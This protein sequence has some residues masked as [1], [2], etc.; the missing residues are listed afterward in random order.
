VPETRTTL[1]VAGAPLGHHDLDLVRSITVE[2]S[3]GGQDKVSVTVALTTDNASGWTGPLDP[4]VAPAS[5]F[6]V[7]LARGADRRDVDARSVSTSW[8]IAPGGLSTITV[9]GLDR[10]VELDRRDVQRLWQDTNDAAIAD[11]LFHEHGLASQVDSTP[12]GADSDTYSPQQSG[13]DWAFLK[14][15]A[16]RNGFDVH[17]QSVNGVVT[18]VF[19]KVDVNADAQATLALG[20]GA[21][22]GQA[23]A[24]V[25]LMA[26]QEVHVTRTV[27][28]TADTDVA[29]DDG[30]GHAMGTRSLGGATLVRTHTAGSVSVLDA[31]TTATAMAE[32]SAFG[33]TLSTTLSSPD[34][35]L[36]RARRTVTVAG[37]GEALDGLWLVRSVR[38]TITPGGHQ[39]AVG[40][41]RNAL[42]NPSLAGALSGALAGAASAV[43][44]VSL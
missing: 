39:Q 43:A 32:R 10:S 7:S 25:Q 35:P 24:S 11:T 17:V 9:E 15:L 23:T 13:T 44:G 1:T 18:G 30:R 37:L 38:H 36:L 28:G 34:A 21:L 27:P 5:P 19:A 12:T 26:G 41:V 20:Y 14:G 29:S 31:Q 6:A 4:L 42:G 40:L 3:L 8:Q 16:G 2:E 33:A 22:G